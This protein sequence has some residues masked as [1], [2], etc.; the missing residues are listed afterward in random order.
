[1]QV[2]CKKWTKK[3]PSDR[4]YENSCP[5]HQNLNTTLAADFNHTYYK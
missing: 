3:Q 2:L 1:M 5:L 4:L